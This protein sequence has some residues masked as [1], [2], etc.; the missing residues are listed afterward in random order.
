MSYIDDIIIEPTFKVGKNKLID[1]T[2]KSVFARL[3]HCITLNT[4]LCYHYECEDYQ[5]R[6]PFEINFTEMSID[7]TKLAVEKVDRLINYLETLEVNKWCARDKYAL[8]ILQQLNKDHTFLQVRYRDRIEIVGLPFYKIDP[9]KAEEK[10][11]KDGTII[12]QVISPFV[13]DW[14][15]YVDHSKKYSDFTLDYNV[16]HLFEHL[17][18]PW[19]ECE[20]YIFMNGFTTVVGVCICSLITSSKKSCI[21]GINEYIK[22]HNEFRQN[23]DKFKDKIEQEVIRTNYETLSANHICA[24]GKS[25]SSIYDKN[26]RYDI[27]KYYASQ[28]FTIVLVV[29][30]MIPWNS[31]NELIPVKNVPKPKP[32]EIKRIPFT[33]FQN[34]EEEPY[35][36]LPSSEKKRFDNIRTQPSELKNVPKLFNST[37]YFGNYIEG[38]DCI[39]VPLKYIDIRD[40]NMMIREISVLEA[41]SIPDYLKTHPLPYKNYGLYML[42]RNSSN[43][44]AYLIDN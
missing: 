27:L 16:L 5:I 2:L 41:K 32:T 35:T 7:K 22:W 1:K 9:I 6:I 25:F 38:V 10:K 23:I 30:E 36:I 42:D 13:S 44:V 17:A 43:L 24:F 28:P 19:H 4:T 8:N 31:I 34:K 3:G 11:M 33:Y 40:N 15:I 37:E 18:V 21:K 26:Y 29:P 39:L 14:G 20:E 12:K